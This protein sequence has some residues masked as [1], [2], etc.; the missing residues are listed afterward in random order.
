MKLWKVRFRGTSREVIVE[1]LTAKK[2][3]ELFAQM[4]GVNSIAMIQA[5]R[6]SQWEAL[7]AS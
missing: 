6:A 7:Q 5:S 2:A 3:K 1:E 4:E